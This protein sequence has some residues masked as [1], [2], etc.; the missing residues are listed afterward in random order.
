MM[1]RTP[2]RLGDIRCRRTTLPQQP[3][4]PKARS[5]GG[6]PV[7]QA[8][9]R[10]PMNTTVQS[11][12]RL[13]KILA[14]CRPFGDAVVICRNGWLETLAVAKWSRP[15]GKA[16]GR[17][18]RGLSR[19]VEPGRGPSLAGAADQFADHL[20]IGCIVI[21]TSILRTFLPHSTVRLLFT[22]YIK[23]NQSV[24][25]ASV[26]TCSHGQPQQCTE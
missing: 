17:V 24:I 13:H 15:Q 10:E 1:R 25:S 8:R 5:K 11:S 14:T 18:P 21:G 9:A 2:L 20:L 26:L 6:K 12:S 7:A 23:L 22:A 3:W 16:D 4:P 19:R